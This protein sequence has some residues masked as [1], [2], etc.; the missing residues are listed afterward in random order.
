MLLADGEHL[1]FENRQ[2]GDL[3]Q[4]SAPAP[5]TMV[6][7]MSSHLTL[8]H[9]SDWHLGHELSGHSREAEHDLFLAWLI[10][11][12][13]AEEADVLLVTGDVYDVANPPVSAMRRLFGF[14]R[15]ATARRPGLQVVILGGNHD[16]A[17]RI[18]LPTALLGDGKVRF[19][20]AFPRRL[21]R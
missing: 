21:A 12:L 2:A 15:E 20:G 6:A 1:A 7:R 4:L 5:G 14:L 16:S 13:D 17:A 18:D 19:I 8:I 9:T 10:E 3:K 11:Q